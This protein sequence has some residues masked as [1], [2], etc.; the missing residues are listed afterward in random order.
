VRLRLRDYSDALMQLAGHYLA[1][2][3]LKDARDTLCNISEAARET[4]HIKM[5]DEYYGLLEI[6]ARQKEL[7]EALEYYY[8][9]VILAHAEHYRQPF[10]NGT[11]L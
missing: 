5:G 9:H 8:R 1:T 11:D 4:I 7:S 10:R 3:R 2:G 6:S